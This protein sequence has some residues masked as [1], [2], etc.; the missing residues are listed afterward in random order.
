MVLGAHYSTDS[1]VQI[2][3]SYPL[4]VE[5]LVFKPVLGTETLPHPPI[6]PGGCSLPLTGGTER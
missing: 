4:P 1:L 5:E 6:R 3:C 2:P